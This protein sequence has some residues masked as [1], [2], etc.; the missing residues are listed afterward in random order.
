[1]HHNHG[2][3]RASGAKEFAM[4]FADSFPIVAADQI[5]TGADDIREPRARLLQRSLN[6]LQTAARLGCRIAE[7]DRFAVGA[8]RGRAADRNDVAY[9]HGARKADARFKRRAGGDQLTWKFHRGSVQQ[10]AS[11]L[12][13]HADDA[14][15]DLHC[16]GRYHDRR[17]GRVGR[18]E[19]DLVAFLVEAFQRG[20]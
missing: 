20:I 8:D 15:L 14:P 4:H 2:A 16:R 5:R 9:S 10:G 7:S 6:D 18:L 13:Q 1:M 17:H 11:V 3:G 19:P 12:S